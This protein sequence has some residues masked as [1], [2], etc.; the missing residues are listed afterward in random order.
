M[1]TSNDVRDEAAWHRQSPYSW[2]WGTYTICAVR[3]RGDVTYELWKNSAF[4]ARASDAA[5]LR[6]IAA[7]G[8]AVA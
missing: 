1:T 2:V 4:V 5:T 8:G 7:A 3:Y 6:T